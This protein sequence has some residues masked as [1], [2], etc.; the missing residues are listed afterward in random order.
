MR[1]LVSSGNHLPQL[2]HQRDWTRY[3]LSA[4]LHQYAASL[5]YALPDVISSRMYVEGEHQVDLL[6][7]VGVLLDNTHNKYWNM[8]NGYCLPCTVHSMA[9]IRDRLDTDATLYDNC[10]R[11]MRV[12]V[13]WDTEVEMDQRQLVTQVFTSALPVAYSYSTKVDDWARFACFMLD[14]AFDAT[15]AVGRVLSHKRG[16]ARVKVYLTPVGGGAFGNQPLWIVQAI[17]KALWKHRQAPLDV[18]LVHYRCLDPKFL[19]IQPIHL[20]CNSTLIASRS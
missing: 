2:L 20:L 12:G 4:Q 9:A 11:A 13:H 16:G 8:Q 6:H 19:T 14:V 7:D 18:V 5:S 3:R 15:L 1:P 10:Y 17:E